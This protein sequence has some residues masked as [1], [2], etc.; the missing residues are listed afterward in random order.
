MKTNARTNSKLWT[1]YAIRNIETERLYVG[2]TGRSDP[3]KRLEEHAA[4]ETNAELYKDLRCGGTARF[5]FFALAAFTSEEAAYR[6]EQSTAAFLSVVVGQ[7]GLYNRRAGGLPAFYNAADRTPV[8]RTGSLV[9]LIAQKLSEL[10]ASKHVVAHRTAAFRRKHGK[11]QGG[12]AGWRNGSETTAQRAARKRDTKA[13]SAAAR[14]EL[15]RERAVWARTPPEHAAVET[16]R[17]GVI[18]RKVTP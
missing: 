7:F 4:H 17:S 12:R 8:T 11:Q 10:G 1:L 18:R 15:D 5:Q 13:K 3:L 14:A 9:P 6:A 2:V 16:V